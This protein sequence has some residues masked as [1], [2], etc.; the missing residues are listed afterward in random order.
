MAS[1]NSSSA[2]SPVWSRFLFPSLPVPSPPISLRS[3][4]EHDSHVA[5][6]LESSDLLLTA[7]RWDKVK[8]SSFYINHPSAY[9]ADVDKGAATLISGYGKNKQHSQFIPFPTPP[10]KNLDLGE[11][12]PPE[13]KKQD[14]EGETRRERWENG[15]E[16]EREVGTEQK[17][18]ELAPV[19]MLT[20]RECARLQGFPESFVIGTGNRYY[21]CFGNA[22]APPVIAA[23][24]SSIICA[25]QHGGDCLHD[26][27]DAAVTC[28]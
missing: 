27:P 28:L 22:V 25:I 14:N 26:G 12:V 21:R 23:I 10:I 17:E 8:T 18:E 1:V 7:K 4:L 15:E 19:R 9:L 13:Q 16:K 2:S 11:V 5:V 3:I 20:P 6:L 24:A